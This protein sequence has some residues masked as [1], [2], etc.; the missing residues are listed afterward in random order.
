MMRLPWPFARTRSS[1]PVDPTREIPAAAPVPTVRPL[2]ILYVPAPHGV[3]E[4]DE[5]TTLTS[6]GH[7][8]FSLGDHHDR[9]HPVSNGRDSKP[10]FFDDAFSELFREDSGCSHAGKR[11]TPAFC[12]H[13]DVI[14]VSGLESWLTEMQDE[15]GDVPVVY[16]TIGQS[17]AGTE[18][19]LARLSGRVGLIRYSPAEVGLP[20][21]APTDA[22]IYFGKDPT[23]YPRWTGGE[24]PITF[25]SHYLARAAICMPGL[26]DYARL[27]EGFD[28]SLYGLRGE[29]AANYRGHLSYEDQFPTLAR[30]G[31]YVYV[32]SMPPSYTLSLIE[33]MFVG[34]PIVAPSRALV[35]SMPADP[36]MAWSPERYEV[37]ALLAD[38]CGFV[39]DSIEEG[40]TMVARLLSDLDL[41][42]ATSV[43]AQDRARALFDNAVIGPQF[44][45]YLARVADR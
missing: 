16:R 45:R 1:T 38:G 36:G 37:E 39:Y 35:S 3:L 25:H 7:R 11:V 19:L 20:G 13:F 43:R 6:A 17:N 2:K 8:V 22:V 18:A 31:C 42:R 28:A 15:I 26:D 23:E 33:A 40:R 10:A 34:T 44:S 41:A 14:L 29:G 21:F 24:G 30:A 9:N 5:L 32:W 12:R 27:T 4:Y